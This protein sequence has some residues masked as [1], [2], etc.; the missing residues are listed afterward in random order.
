M[1][2]LDRGGAQAR[3]GVAA[4][5]H[6]LCASRGAARARMDGGRG[7]SGPAGAM[8][9]DRIRLRDHHLFRVERE[10]APWA[11]ALLLA[12]SVATAILC[13]HRPFAFPA[14]LGIAAMAAGF[15]V[16]TVKREVIAHPVLAAPVWNVEL[17]GF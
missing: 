12:A 8:A 2:A 3:T 10:P 13:R 5:P 15:A 4:G 11:A 16:A 9:R 17:A 6:G 1:A 7:C 14:A